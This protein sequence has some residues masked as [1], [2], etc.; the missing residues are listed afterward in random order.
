MIKLAFIVLAVG[1]GFIFAMERPTAPGQPLQ[2]V[3]SITTIHAIKECCCDRGYCA[4]CSVACAFCCEA[5]MRYFG[6]TL[7][8]HVQSRTCRCTTP[9]QIINKTIQTVEAAQIIASTSA[10]VGINAYYFRKH[11]KEKKD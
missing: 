8:V 1:P 5:S 10:L 11:K 7:L 4:R 2:R 6:Y 3:E 9:G